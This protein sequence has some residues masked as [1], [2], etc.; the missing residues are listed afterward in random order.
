M[1]LLGGKHNNNSSNS[2]GEN[3]SSDSKKSTSKHKASNDNNASSDSSSSS[4]NATILL[5]LGSLPINHD[6]FA[7]ETPLFKGHVMIRLA[8]LP[9]SSAD[10]FEG[11]KRKLQVCLVLI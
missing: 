4:S 2:S 11:K 6:P 1:N 5:P 7:F 9:S 8:D 10:Y 3:I